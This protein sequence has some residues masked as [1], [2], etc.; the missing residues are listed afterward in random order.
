MQ[1]YKWQIKKELFND[2]YLTFRKGYLPV[3][4]RADFKC[5]ICKKNNCRLN[6]HHKDKNHQNN[7]LDNLILVCSK[8]HA[9]FHWEEFEKGRAIRDSK[10][11]LSDW[12]KQLI[13]ELI[14]QGLS[15]SQIGKMMG[16][17]KQRVFQIQNRG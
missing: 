15:L 1:N 2:S 3:Y 6:V 4:K 14:E 8:H 5:E 7:S 10:N 17:T 9:M 16:I 12:R 11:S 13:L